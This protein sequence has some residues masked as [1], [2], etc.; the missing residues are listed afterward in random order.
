ML[1][2]CSG[3]KR[4]LTHMIEML[5]YSF[6]VSP[7]GS[8]PLEQGWRT[9]ITTRAWIAILF[10]HI[11]CSICVTEFNCEMVGVAI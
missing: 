11:R 2:V 9:R 6:I 4:A 1:V 10:W 3:R 8:Y 5:K 7:S